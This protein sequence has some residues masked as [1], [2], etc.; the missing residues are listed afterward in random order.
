MNILYNLYSLALDQATSSSLVAAETLDIEPIDIAIDDSS[1][2][3]G[4]HLLGVCIYDYMRVLHSR[5][6]PR[7]LAC[8]LPR[9]RCTVNGMRVRTTD[10]LRE[11]VAAVNES[12]FHSL[13]P[14]ATQ[15]VM[16][17][18]LQLLTT[19][20]GS[21]CVIADARGNLVVCFVVHDDF[22]TVQVSKQMRV[23]SPDA[24]AENGTLLDIFV[25]YESL[26][27]SVLVYWCEVVSC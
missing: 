18:P 16:A 5:R 9:L 19:A 27:N 26:A 12:Y 17:V 6:L 1:D 21:N 14:F 13:A 4:E 3:S 8:D 20:Y 10:Q 2:N 22:W 11:A 23:L 24:S 15:T 7:Q 25:V